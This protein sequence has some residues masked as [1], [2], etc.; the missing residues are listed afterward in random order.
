M[1]A[2]RGHCPKCNSTNTAKEKIMGNQTGD[3]ICLDCRYIGCALE[4]RGREVG[5][6]QEVK[7]K[8]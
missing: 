5:S 1:G 2:Y 4:F 8:S 3:L 7:K 6:D